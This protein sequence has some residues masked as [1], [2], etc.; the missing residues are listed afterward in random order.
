MD[1]VFKALA[2]P[3]RRALLDSLNARLAQHD[4]P[5]AVEPRVHFLHA[6]E[7]HELRSVDAHELIRIELADRLLLLSGGRPVEGRLQSSVAGWA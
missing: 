4:Q 2:D 3:S 7:V 6:V 1:E 5:V